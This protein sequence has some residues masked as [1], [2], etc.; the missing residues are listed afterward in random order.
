MMVDRDFMIRIIINGIPDSDIHRKL[1]IKPDLD[2]KT[3]I[4]TCRQEEAGK[5][6]DVMVSRTLGTNLKSVTKTAP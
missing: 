1:H 6:A 5:K 4:V 3:A 2:L